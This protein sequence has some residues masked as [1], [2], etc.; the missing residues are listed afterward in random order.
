MKFALNIKGI[1]KN[2]QKKKEEK[3]KEIK[4]P[5]L[6]DFQKDILI[7]KNEK[8]T[9]IESKKKFKYPK[10]FIIDINSIKEE[11]EKNIQRK[12]KEINDSSL[13]DYEKREKVLKEMKTTENE[14]ILKNEIIENDGNKIVDKMDIKNIYKEFSITDIL[15][16][17]SNSINDSTKSHSNISLNKEE[18]KEKKE[19]VLV[20]NDPRKV[21]YKKYKLYDYPLYDK[22][23]NKIIPPKSNIDENIFVFVYPNDLRTYYITKSFCIGKAEN[24]KELDEKQIDDSIFDESIGLYFCGK[25]ENENINKICA[26]DIFMCKNCMKLNKK[27]YY[28]K[29]E[30]LININGRVTKKNKGKYHCFGHFLI[31]YQLFDCIN[32]FCCEACKELNLISDYYLCK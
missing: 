28:I 15:N 17:N 2:A 7:L 29:D 3:K 1:R 16:N 8:T 32:K 23:L 31:K 12:K 5:N 4:D 6:S 22:E 11:N 27:N 25:N 18:N 21:Y 13:S 20:F 19:N 14:K 26:K 30:H 24:K 10:I 9:E